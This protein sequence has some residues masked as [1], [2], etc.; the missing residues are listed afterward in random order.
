MK[1]TRD[2]WKRCDKKHPCKVCGKNDWCT[3]SPDG[4]F[5]VCMRVADQGALRA[6]KNGGFLFRLKET[7]QPLRRIIKRQTREAPKELPSLIPAREFELEASARCL[8]LPPAALLEYGASLYDTGLAFPMY[9]GAGERIG[10]RIRLGDGKKFCVTG[11]RNGIFIPH[12][13]TLDKR[14][15]LFVVEGP[16]DAAA[17]FSLGLQAIGRPSNTGGHEL[18]VE[19][20]AGFRQVVILVDRDSNPQA[21]QGTERAAQNLAMALKGIVKIFHPPGFKDAR[22][23]ISQGSATASLILSVLQNANAIQKPKER[24]RN[25]S[26]GSMR[27]A[28]QIE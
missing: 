18:L 9:D 12:F 26:A 8:G 6:V 24:F 16:T 27:P 10:Y 17:L 20:L 25:C 7:P 22:E 1:E 5:A 14:E 13:F 19:F 11:S 15:P 21:R 4:S 2:G 3:E 23:W 28:F